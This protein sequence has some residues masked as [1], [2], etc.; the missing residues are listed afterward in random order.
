MP[1]WVPLRAVA[2]WFALRSRLPGACD[3]AMLISAGGR[4][5]LSARDEAVARGAN[6][7]LRRLGVNCL[8]RATVVTSLLRERGVD[9]RIRLS[10]RRSDPSDAHAEVEVGTRSLQ[11][12]ADDFVVLR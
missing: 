1:L 2:R 5:E 4:T 6:A 12:E 7:T 11:I 9:A 10:V 8:G 3:S